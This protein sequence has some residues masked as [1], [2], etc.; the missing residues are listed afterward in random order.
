MLL[1]FR[2]TLHA[3][4]GRSTDEVGVTEPFCQRLKLERER[5]VSLEIDE[6]ASFPKKHV[7]K[8]IWK[9]NWRR[10]HWWHIKKKKSKAVLTNRFLAFVVT[11]LSTRF[12][13][14]VA[15]FFVRRLTGTKLYK[16]TC[17]VIKKIDLE[18]FSV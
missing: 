8:T 1:P 7:Y 4:I 15:Y 16:L 11:G 10:E 2:Y 14:P 9:N 3:Y 5:R 18:G 12:K 6:M 17:H 13:I